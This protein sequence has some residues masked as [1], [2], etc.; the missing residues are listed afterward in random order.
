MEDWLKCQISPLYILNI[1]KNKNKHTY[2]HTDGQT[3]RRTDVHTVSRTD[4]QTYKRIYVQTDRRTVRR[5]DIQTDIHTDGQT[6][7]VNPH[8]QLRLRLQLQYWFYPRAIF[9]H[10]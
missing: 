2:I 7:F 4:G 3:D 5:T 6:L 10:T 1:M 9:T 8:Y